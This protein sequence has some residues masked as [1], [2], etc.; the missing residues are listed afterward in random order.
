MIEARPSIFIYVSQPNKSL[1]TEIVSGI[2]EEGVLYQI[3]DKDGDD[4]LTLAYDAANTSTLGIGIGL[5]NDFGVLQMQKLPIDAPIFKIM[6]A[7]QFRNLGTNAARAV[8]GQ[9][10]RV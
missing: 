5:V 1:L 6:N 3:F 9:P 2:E 8:K 10:F 4:A 7:E